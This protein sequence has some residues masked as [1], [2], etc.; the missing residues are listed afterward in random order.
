MRIAQTIAAAAALVTTATPGTA[1]NWP[2]RPVTMVVPY[3]AGAGVDVMGRILSPRLSE[4]LGQQVIVENVSGA[5]GM[6]GAA[7]VAKAPPD[8]YQFVIGN[9][10]THAQIQTASKHPAYNAATDFAPVVLIAQTPQVLLTRKDLPAD[11]LQ[12]FTSRAKQANMQY[13]SAGVGSP[14]H[15]TCAL[16]NTAI[17]IN[18]TH[19]PYRGAAP[20]L[21]DLIAGRI[22]Y[23][24]TIAPSA[25]P[26]IESKT[27]K[28]IALL[29]RERSSSLPTLASAQ[30]QGLGGFD[31]ST[32]FAFFFPKATPTAIVEKLR[33]TT[34]E[35]MN[36]PAVQERMKEVGNES[37]APE[38]RSPEYLQ[39]LVVS[40]TEK[41]AAVIKG[42]GITTE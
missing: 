36:N 35:V 27:V 33:V 13:G 5:G 23:L 34:V 15:L 7:R 4:L 3:P 30:E 14:G 40:E 28:A 32:W 31:A 26:Q 18:A 37:I 10:A 29:S 6:T 25:I 9:T 16:L 20:A 24:C 12:E 39:N 41:W 19:I 21:Q 8:G 2:T 11:N 42:A 17:G 38:R 22:D 1:Q